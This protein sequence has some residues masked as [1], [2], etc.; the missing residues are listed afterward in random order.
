[1]VPSTDETPIQ[2][3]GPWGN[4][5]SMT[6]QTDS[7]YLPP[8]PEEMEALVQDLLAQCPALR[9]DSA[10]ATDATMAIIG[11]ARDLSLKWTADIQELMRKQDGAIPILVASEVMAYGAMSVIMADSPVVLKDLHS[12]GAILG[13]FIVERWRANSR[14]AQFRASQ[15]QPD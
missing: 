10:E 5:P 12:A 11:S 2:A 8:T 15:G 7:K 13:K 9:V 14:Q 3:C 1:M 6:T 4:V